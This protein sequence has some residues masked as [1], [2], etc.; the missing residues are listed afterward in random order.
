MDASY[1]IVFCNERWELGKQREFVMVGHC[2]GGLVLKSL[3]VE[4]RTIAKRK[5]RNMFLI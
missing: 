4:A 1:C 2:F 5:P 3:M